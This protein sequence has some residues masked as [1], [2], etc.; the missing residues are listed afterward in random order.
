MH[1]RR[2]AILAMMVAI[3][4]FFVG[5]TIAPASSGRSTDPTPTCDFN[6]NDQGEDLDDQGEDVDGTDVG[7]DIQGTALD[8]SLDGNGGADDIDGNDGNDDI[9][10]DQGDDQ[11]NG[12]QGEIGRASC[13]ERG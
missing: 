9:C 2:L 11:E 4:V 5:L 1:K 8:D 13:R 6:E 3:G 7:D 12:D 10:G